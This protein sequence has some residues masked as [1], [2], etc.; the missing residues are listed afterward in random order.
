MAS[1][2]LRY[3]TSLRLDVNVKSKN[4]SYCTCMCDLYMSFTLLL[5][6]LLNRDGQLFSLQLCVME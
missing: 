2:L 5:T 3:Q 4:V 1:T 6:Y